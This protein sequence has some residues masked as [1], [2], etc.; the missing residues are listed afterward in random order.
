MTEFA[1]RAAQACL[2]LIGEKADRVDYPAGRSRRSVRV[3]LTGRSVIVTRRRN[4]AR[5]IHEQRILRDLHAAGAP[6]PGIL[7][8]GDGWL[9]QQDLGGMRLTGAI[10]DASTSEVET[11]LDRALDALAR[12]HAAGRQAGL[13]EGPAQLGATD[14]WLHTFAE[15]PQRVG[16]AAGLAPADYDADSLAGRMR[17]PNPAFIKWDARPGNALLGDDGAVYWF[18]WEHAGIRSPLDDIG[19]LLGDEYVA[20]LPDAEAALLRRHIDVFGGGLPE[21]EARDYLATFLALHACVRLSL[22]L[23]YRQRD[24][25]WWNRSQS[26]GNDRVGVDQDSAQA[27]CAKGVRWASQS[28]ALRPLAAWFADL[29]TVIAAMP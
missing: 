1:E 5:G 4:P 21:S 8:W 11:L 7:A 17:P 19:W 16:V 12:C 18:D 24:G 13:S 29:G 3:H 2:T 6:V 9:V 27:L 25:H 14:N 15:M 10:A 20:D 22:I 26:I 28:A 23:S